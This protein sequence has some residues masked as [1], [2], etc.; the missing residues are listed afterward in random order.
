M[1]EVRTLTVASGDTLSDALNLQNAR[2][3]MLFVPT[4]TPSCDTFLRASTDATS[5]TSKRVQNISYPAS[6]DFRIPTGIGSSCIAL[7]EDI[8]AAVPV[9]RLELGAAT[10]APTFFLLAVKFT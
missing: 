9:M 4:L 3:A 1:F 5:A 8:V 6:G 7:R 2:A 10:T